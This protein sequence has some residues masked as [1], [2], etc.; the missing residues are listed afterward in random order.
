M[1]DA[2]IRCRHFTPATP[3]YDT[4][5]HRAFDYF[6]FRH[7]L[8]SITWLMIMLAFVMRGR[9]APC[10]YDMLMRQQKDDED[11]RYAAR[12]SYEAMSAMRD[13]RSICTVCEDALQMRSERAKMSLLL[14]HCCQERADDAVVMRAA[15][16]RWRYLLRALL[17]DATP[18]F[19]FDAIDFRFSCRYIF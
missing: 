5:R 13:E 3:R 1:L 14:R 6:D 16:I 10:A 11:M 15:L 7:A 9:C 8:L 12:H 2:T 18:L 19:T 17:R 4:R